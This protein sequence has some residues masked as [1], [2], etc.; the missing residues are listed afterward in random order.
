M[1]LNKNTQFEC[2]KCGS[3]K[4]GYQ[5]GVLCVSPVIIQS[6]NQ[7]EYCQFKMGEDDDSCFENSF[8]CMDCNNLVSHCGGRMETEEQL[9]AYLSMDHDLRNTERAEYEE[10]LRTHEGAGDEDG[11]YYTD[12]DDLLIK[13]PS[14]D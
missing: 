13:D 3:N 7:A 12:L 11:M 6:D 5:K 1:S 9:I 4:L 14:K 10:F 2:E 8:L